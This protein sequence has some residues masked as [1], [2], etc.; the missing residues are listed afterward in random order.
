MTM[1]AKGNEHWH[2]YVVTAV[3]TL[4]AFALL[5]LLSGGF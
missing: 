3:A 5:M 2:G 1:R 4:T